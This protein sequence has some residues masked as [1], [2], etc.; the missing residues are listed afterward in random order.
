MY[1]IAEFGSSCRNTSDILSDRDLLIVCQKGNHSSLYKRYSNYGYS[2]S[3]FT[4]E[5]LN[6]MKS[7][8]SLFLQHLRNEANV[9]VDS[10]GNFA[11][12]LSSCDLVP[13]SVGELKKCMATVSY[14]GS[15]PAPSPLVAWKADF[16]YCITRDLL[17]KKLAKL[18]IVAF[19]IEELE[20]HSC[21][22][23]DISTVEFKNMFSL[24]RAKA[25]Y[26]SKSVMPED[27]WA[28]MNAWLDVITRAF[29]IATSNNQPI[30]LQDAKSIVRLKNRQFNSEY[31]RLRSLEG[32]YLLARSKN[33]LHPR[34]DSLMKHIMS[35]NLYGSSQIRKRSQIIRF[36][37]DAVD[38]LTEN[39][40]FDWQGSRSFAEVSLK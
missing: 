13:P 27:T 5:Q 35:P 12:F 8:G 32:L 30:N 4:P 18:G 37:N 31:E 24:R 36:L 2:V 21:A 23:L 10:N 17:I 19:G 6:H 20:S 3:V 14:I 25:A 33:L 1:A 22:Y 16:L 28:A 38:I 11:Q 40:L 34:H 29:G 15:W 7:Q 39:F 9:L 26:R